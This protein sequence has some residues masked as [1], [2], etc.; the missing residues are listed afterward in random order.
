MSA[1]TVMTFGVF[2][3]NA[4]QMVSGETSVVA[5]RTAVRGLAE[6]SAVARPRRKA[7]GGRVL[8][9]TPPDLPARL[10]DERNEQKHD[11]GDREDA[12]RHGLD[13]LE[14]DHDDV[15]L[16]ARDCL[17]VIECR[18]DEVRTGNDEQQRQRHRLEDVREPLLE[19]HRAQ[20]DEKHDEAAAGEGKVLQ[21]DVVDEREHEHENHAPEV[22]GALP[23]HAAEDV[24]TVGAGD[25]IT[26]RRTIGT[27]TSRP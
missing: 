27:M 13:P 16:T 14:D 20:V 26:S 11:E 3:D 15:R 25:D 2:I 7:V 24:G 10:D 21:Q 22:D 4:S 1:V 9:T 8:V 18:L 12:Q 5:R 19:G 23:A 17:R 6:T